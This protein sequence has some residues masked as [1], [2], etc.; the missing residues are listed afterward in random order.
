MVLIHGEA[1]TGTWW[2]FKSPLLLTRFKCT[3][4]HRG[5]RSWDRNVM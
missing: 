4:T 1:I 5:I 3:E 2:V